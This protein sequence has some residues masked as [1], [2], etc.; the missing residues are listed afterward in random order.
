MKL[1]I[2]K[3]ALA[4]ALAAV[5][6]VS[7]TRAEMPVLKFAKLEIDVGRIS[8]T[9][10]GIDCFYR[11]IVSRVEGHNPDAC[12]LP[13]GKVKDWLSRVGDG[14]VNIEADANGLKLSTEDSGVS[15]FATYKVEEFPEAPQAPK[16]ITIVAD[17]EP[18][19]HIAWSV[20]DA[21]GGK[22]ALEEAFIEHEN[23]GIVGA[24]ADGRKLGVVKI[25]GEINDKAFIMS[26]IALPA[27]YISLVAGL[28]KCHLHDSEKYVH[29]IGEDFNIAIRKSEH[30]IPNW[31]VMMSNEK[32]PV[33]GSITVMR[34][35]LAQS[36]N[37]CHLLKGGDI[38]F[39]HGVP[40]TLAKTKTG[41]NITCF[42]QKTA[43]SHTRDIDGRIKG[44]FPT[45]RLSTEHIAPFFNLPDESPL[46]IQFTGD[47]TMVRMDA[48]EIGVSYFF[49]PLFPETKG[50]A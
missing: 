1:T 49:C 28:G 44:E 23:G 3:S 22:P 10:A 2:Q 30:G 27:K 12:L 21:N 24:T 17:F 20:L 48:E 42:V 9:A 25:D 8:L 39:E 29:F 14:E 5:S 26:P 41:L 31:R 11:R 33:I 38:G 15:R 45:V 37:L 32:F 35:E 46:K 18:L 19:K 4:Q 6:A 40:I 7:P 16:Q 47:R 13:I 36:V 43:E 50:T 34:D